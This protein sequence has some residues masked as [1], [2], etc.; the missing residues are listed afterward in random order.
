MQELGYVQHL[1]KNVLSMLLLENFVFLT[2]LLMVCCDDAERSKQRRRPTE[3]LISAIH[4]E[5]GLRISCRGSVH[6]D[7]TDLVFVI[8]EQTQ[9][10]HVHTLSENTAFCLPRQEGY[11]LLQNG[12]VLLL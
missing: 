10:C 7:Y 12:R 11:I 2:M 6:R 3:V 5:R 8:C 1:Y 4:E 9:Q